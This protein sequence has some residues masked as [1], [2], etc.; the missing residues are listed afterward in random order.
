MIPIFLTHPH[1]AAPTN[2]TNHVHIDTKGV[3]RSI[4]SLTSGVNS[5][6][7]DVKRIADVAESSSVH[8]P[9]ERLRTLL[10]LAV[11]LAYDE[12][13]R[14]RA[15]AGVIQARLHRIRD[16][17]DARATRAHRRAMDAKREQYE[18]RGTRLEAEVENLMFD[19]RRKAYAQF[20]HWLHR[21]FPK[22]LAHFQE[23]NG[24]FV[25]EQE[26][27]AHYDNPMPSYG[28]M[29][30]RLG[31]VRARRNYIRMEYVI[32]RYT[33]PHP[34]LPH[35][36]EMIQLL[37]LADNLPGTTLEVEHSAMALIIQTAREAEELGYEVAAK[38][39]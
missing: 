17:Q 9:T 6:G 27:R 4:D 29:G 18:M 14:Y 35:V 32:G 38:N 2:I 30:Q 8:V 33:K 16:W 10:S 26:M 31:I 23:M 20:R 28:D 36:D 24:Y 12:R 1:L 21:W 3:Q 5:I 7:S 34:S 22:P 13:E 15:E 11:G 25:A 39:D 37:E 19:A